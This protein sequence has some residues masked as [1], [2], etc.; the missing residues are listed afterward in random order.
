MV[1]TEQPPV[2][3]RG[4][5]R[6][7]PRVEDL[8]AG[9]ASRQPQVEIDL[10][11]PIRSG[12]DRRLKRE[13]SLGDE[14]PERGPG[15]NHQP[16]Q[17]WW[18]WLSSE[19][20]RRRRAGEPGH[21]A[22]DHLTNRPVRTPPFEEVGIGARGPEFSELRVAPGGLGRRELSSGP[23]HAPDHRVGQRPDRPQFV[24]GHDH[25][26]SAVSDPPEGLADPVRVARIEPAEWFVSHQAGGSPRDGDG[27][28]GPAAFD[29]WGNGS[30]FARN[31]TC[32]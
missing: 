13:P 12:H 2:G 14:D 32:R 4:N 21:L 18:T 11:P 27:D 9:I 1:D 24:A 28:L 6:P 8:D 19:V 5:H 10:L 22:P 15:V 25:G 16:R 17:R 3:G 23:G 7:A 30:S 29:A 26:G 20:H 31:T